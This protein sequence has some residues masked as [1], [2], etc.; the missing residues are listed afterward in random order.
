M[1]G[2]CN[3]PVFIPHLGCNNECVFC[4]QRSITGRQKPPNAEEVRKIIDSYL[5]YA[6]AR[7]KEIAFFGGSF[8]GL[9]ASE[10]AEYLGIAREYA[11]KG[12]VSGVRISTRPDYID[13][14][15]LSRLKEFGVTAIELGV[16]S[17]C[18][19]VLKRAKRGHSSEQS[20][21]AAR[22][23]KERGFA[24]GLQ[25]MIGLPGD[26][27]EKSLFTAREIV[28]LGADC[29][30]IYPACVLYDTQ[31]FEMYKQSEYIPLTV[32]EAA[33]TAKKVFA[34][35]TDG[36]V[37]VIRMGLQQTDALPESIAAG[38]YHPAFGEIVK[39]LIA[40]DEM[41]RE[42]LSRGGKRVVIEVAKGRMSQFAGHK[43]SN[44]KYFKDKYAT[45]VILKESGEQ[46]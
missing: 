36:G 40:R 2:H 7:E 11:S 22:M 44:L 42:V 1:T 29:A 9:P 25:M 24:L 5:E 8:T 28:R 31:M 14:Q 6:A 15:T 45:D 43:K 4:N 26:T 10:Q 34:I 30:R 13:T 12:L 18:D 23:I 19:E 38:P 41:E 39:A 3:I 46:Q 33:N 37:R 21:K 27:E 16:Q 32:D 17:M 35:L 20:E